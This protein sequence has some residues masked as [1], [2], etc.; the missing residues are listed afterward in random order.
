ME[1]IRIDDFLPGLN[2]NKNRLLLLL[3]NGEIIFPKREMTTLDLLGDWICSDGKMISKIE[4]WMEI[5]LPRDENIKDLR[6][7]YYE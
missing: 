6:S 4:Y 5:K 1:W 3:K 7:E 2:I